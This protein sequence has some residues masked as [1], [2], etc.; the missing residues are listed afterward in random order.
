MRRGRPVQTLDRIL[1][2]P[3]YRQRFACPQ[4]TRY[5]GSLTVATTRRRSGIELPR[6]SVQ[7]S[8]RKKSQTSNSKA[9]GAG[10][11]GVG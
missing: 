10:L 2:A 5:S 11:K 3:Y 6:R 9:R 4:S 1:G 8:L 7:Q